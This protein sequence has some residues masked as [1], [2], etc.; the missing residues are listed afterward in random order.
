MR[1]ILFVPGDS[2]RKLAKAPASG[3]DILVLDLEDAVALDAKQ[4]ARETTAAYLAE[5]TDR[6]SLP[7][8]YVRINDL[9]TGLAEDDLDAV[10]PARPAG[11]MLPKPRSGRDVAALGKMLD[12]HENAAGIATG[13]LPVLTIANEVA[14][15]VVNM[16][17]FIDADPR[18]QGL[19]WGSE[20]LA[21][22]IGAKANR[23]DNTGA[24]IP[25]LLFS[26]NLCVLTAA[27][28]NVFAIDTV[29]T[30]FRDPVGLEAEARDAA[31]DGFTG[32][33]AIHPD[34]IPI[35]ND[36]FTPSRDEIAEAKMIFEAFEAE[37][38]AGV[39]SL[40]GRMIDRPHLEAA[41]RTL[42]KAQLAGL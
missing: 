34:Q 27:A 33:M 32:K 35:I 4:A 14:S 2:D 24:Y 18:L 25:P 21:T 7:P 28:A 10:I 16:A 40:D 23:D 41:K 3:A 29:F 39:I 30:N 5:H 17:S 1:S 12:A 15:A 11:I 37:P 22:A 26:R 31:R 13:S 36:A 9:Q 6:E 42:G 19:C 38:G 8:L 20:D